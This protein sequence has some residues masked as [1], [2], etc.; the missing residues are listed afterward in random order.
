[1]SM[2]AV[3]SIRRNLHIGETVRLNIAVS[4]LS[5][6]WRTCMANLVTVTLTAGGGAVPYCHGQTAW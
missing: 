3:L 6:A 2:V 4:G 5:R 1:M